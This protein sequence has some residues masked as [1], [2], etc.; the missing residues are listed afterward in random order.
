M[1]GRSDE[2]RD[3]SGEDVM[4]VCATEKVEM[5]FGECNAPYMRTRVSSPPPLPNLDRLASTNQLRNVKST[6]FARPAVHHGVQRGMQR[7]C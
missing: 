6:E 5:K 3:M 4:K 1:L 7:A 2:D